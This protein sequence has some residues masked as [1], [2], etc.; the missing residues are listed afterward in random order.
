MHSQVR[1]RIFLQ[2]GNLKHEE[3]I[4]KLIQKWILGTLEP[5]YRPSLVCE[6]RTLHPHVEDFCEYGNK[7]SRTACRGWS[8][9]L[10]IALGL[11]I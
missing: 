2:G 1:N 3:G 8:S 10:R 7:Q 11:I 6:R 9:R 5:R 4:W